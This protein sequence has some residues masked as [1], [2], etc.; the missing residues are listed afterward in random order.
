MRASAELATA[1]DATAECEQALR[2]SGLVHAAAHAR[3]ASACLRLASASVLKRLVAEGLFGHVG[4]ATA[5]ASA[6]ARIPLTLEDGRATGFAL[7]RAGNGLG[8]KVACGVA[9]ATLPA[10]AA[11]DLGWDVLNSADARRLARLDLDAALLQAALAATGWV[12]P[13]RASR[14]TGSRAT[15]GTVVRILRDGRP[16][17]TLDDTGGL[18][19]DVGVVDL[20]GQLGWRPELRD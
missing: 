1:I 10:I 5:P 14:W 7:A 11:H 15:A 13:E 19:L 16:A 4:L 2:S 9:A 12:S 6:P 17:P 20:I 3:T 18:L 8:R